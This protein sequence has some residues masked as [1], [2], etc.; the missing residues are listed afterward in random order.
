M[1]Y[2]EFVKEG[3]INFFSYKI[4]YFESFELDFS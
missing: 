4:K 3:I 2:C 1:L